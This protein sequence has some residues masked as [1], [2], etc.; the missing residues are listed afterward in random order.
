MKNILSAKWMLICFLILIMSSCVSKRK[1]MD[2]MESVEK[3]KA[4][5]AECASK[6]ASLQQNVSKL[7]ENSMKMKSEIDSSRNRASRYQKKFDEFESYYDQLA[8]STEELRS[9]LILALSGTGLSEENVQALNGLLII[10]VPKEML[11]TSGANLSNQGKATLVKIANFTESNEDYGVD[12]AT[13]DSYKDFASR[14]EKRENMIRGRRSPDENMTDITTKKDRRL[15]DN[16][17]KQ[18]PDTIALMHSQRGRDKKMTDSSMIKSKNKADRKMADTAK[19]TGGA[20]NWGTELSRA[21]S[22]V[23]VLAQNGAA[24]VR[25]IAPVYSQTR[26]TVTT[27]PIAEKG[28]YIIISRK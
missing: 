17:D 18:I 26:N 28:Y 9:K 22:I 19:R 3:Y 8:K 7:E 2:A 5:S 11:F 4:E 23:K 14:M 27:D 13:G 20:E 12:V 25:L 15:P 6:S 24:E 10:N 1:Y 21:S 16:S